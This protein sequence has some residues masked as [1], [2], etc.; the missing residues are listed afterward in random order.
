MLEFAQKPCVNKLEAI[1]YII[2]E[3]NLE[4]IPR[5]MLEVELEAITKTTLD[6]N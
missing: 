5:T 6:F 3:V 1:A 4:S 2:L